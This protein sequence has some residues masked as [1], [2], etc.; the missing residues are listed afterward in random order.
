[1]RR[2]TPPESWGK[3]PFPNRPPKSFSRTFCGLPMNLPSPRALTS[4]VART[5][6]PFAAAI[7][8]LLQGE[9][10]VAAMPYALTV[11]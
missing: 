5:T 4:V 11:Q 3:R 7:G 10:L 1:M 6:R 9:R 2:I 8:P